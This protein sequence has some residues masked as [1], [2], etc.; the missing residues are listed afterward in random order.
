MHHSSLQ[1]T[2]D[3]SDGFQ[4]QFCCC[5]PAERFQSFKSSN[6][7]TSSL[8]VLNCWT[9]KI[10]LQPTDL[11]EKQCIHTKQNKTNYCLGRFSFHLKIKTASLSPWKKK[12]DIKKMI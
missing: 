8:C 3:H 2:Q 4:Y 11:H 9:A 7:F 10:M 6:L 12:E 5:T 1:Y